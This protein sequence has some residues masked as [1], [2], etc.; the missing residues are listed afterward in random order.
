MIPA[1]YL[2]DHRTTSLASVRK[3]YLCSHCEMLKLAIPGG[4]LGGPGRGFGMREG[5]KARGRMIQ[6]I[7]AAH[8]EALARVAAVTT[9]TDRT[10]T[11]ATILKEKRHEKSC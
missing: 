7:K 5:N 9:H 8:P 10:A 1:D 3:C 4:L 11:V 6:H 2:Y